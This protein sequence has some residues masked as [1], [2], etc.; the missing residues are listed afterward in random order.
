ML[1]R[2][3]LIARRELRRRW[4]G[5]LSRPARGPDRRAGF[6]DENPHLDQGSRKLSGAVKDHI[7]PETWKGDCNPAN[8]DLMLCWKKGALLAK[9]ALTEHDVFA[10]ADV[11]FDAIAATGATMLTPV[12]GEMR[13]GV[14]VE[15][16][17]RAAQ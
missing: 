14:R 11:N 12:P 8:V 2:A 15:L 13:P 9:E 5:R 17:A 16:R 10:D 6:L 1:C 3:L 7:N 4:P